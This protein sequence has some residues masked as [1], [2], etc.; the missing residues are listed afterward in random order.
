MSVQPANSGKACGTLVD[1]MPCQ[2]GGTAAFALGPITLPTW[3]AYNAPNFPDKT[4]QVIWSTPNAA[5]VEDDKQPKTFAYVYRNDTGAPISA[6][7]NI[8]VDD[9]ATVTATNSGQTVLSAS[10]STF[11]NI[12]KF[13]VVVP[14]GDTMFKVVAR[15]G[16]GP[17]GLVFSVMDGSNKVLFNTA[18][19][20][21]TWVQGNH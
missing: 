2:V 7:A 16:Q 11:P 15:N 4:A 5:T 8:W 9:I 3:T 10:S 18:S 14:P 1:T 12:G 19:T 20:G 13:A 17:S 6:T 21:W